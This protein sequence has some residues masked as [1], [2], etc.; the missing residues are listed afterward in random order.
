[1]PLHA[2]R[3][4][5]GGHSVEQKFDR[6]CLRLGLR[7]FVVLCPTKQTPIRVSV[8]PQP[9]AVPHWVEWISPSEWYVPLAPRYEVPHQF[10]ERAIEAVCLYSDGD[11]V[12]N[13]MRKLASGIRPE[14]QHKT[15]EFERNPLSVV[16]TIL[17]RLDVVGGLF[18]SSTHT[19]DFVSK[20]PLQ[21]YL[22][23]T[24]FDRLG[25]PANWMDFGAWLTSKECAVCA[26][27]LAGSQCGAASVGFTKSLYADY[28]ERYGVKNSFFR[29]VQ[30]ILPIEARVELLASIETTS[31]TLPPVLQ[32]LPPLTEL[33]K[34]RYLYKRRND[35][36][37]KAAFIPKCG[38][39]YMRSYTNRTQVVGANSWS[40]TTTH[41]WPH[42]L[43]R[44]VRRGLASYLE[45]ASQT[46]A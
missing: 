21:S 29:F 10:V 43:E 41:G 30:D 15:S 34:I 17:E 27:N 18:T 42:I 36:T 24:C 46:G 37:H 19:P 14:H 4:A 23:L 6:N 9:G 12:K 3:F 5:V 35:Y 38:D 25:Q 40:D 26:S 31:L 28:L 7:L 8:E 33:E 16:F 45:K 2:V 1:M 11:T 32:Y 44:C 13:A 20:E 22:L 39:W